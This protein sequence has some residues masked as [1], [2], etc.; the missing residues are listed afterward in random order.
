MNCILSEVIVTKP[1]CWINKKCCAVGIGL[2]RQ[3]GINLRCYVGLDNE[4]VAV[5]AVEQSDVTRSY[6]AKPCQR[7]DLAHI[8][9]RKT[10]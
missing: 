10:Y 7:R 1:C 9:S 5:I 3:T 4:H 6:P 8:D 2:R